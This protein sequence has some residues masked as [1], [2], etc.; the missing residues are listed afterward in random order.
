MNI[1]LY[2]ALYTF[3]KIEIDRKKNRLSSE[4]YGEVC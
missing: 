2:F 1:F 3:I 4:K